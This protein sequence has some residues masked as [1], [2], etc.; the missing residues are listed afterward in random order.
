MNPLNYV[1]LLEEAS[2]KTSLQKDMVKMR[3]YKDLPGHLGYS[4]V[5]VALASGSAKVMAD[6]HCPLGT[7]WMLQSDTWA[8]HSLGEAPFLFDQDG[9]RW[10]RE[11]DSDSISSRFQ[12]FGNLACSAPGYNCRVNIAA[13][14]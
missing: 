3:G 1:T 2:A 5:S 4:A 11:D 10:G 14:D 9:N 13:V 12:V 6:K 7:A 8:F